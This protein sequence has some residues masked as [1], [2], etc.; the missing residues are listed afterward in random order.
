MSARRAFTL[1]ELLV[2]IAIIAILMSILLP[3]LNRVREQ[4]K[5]AACLSN[6]RQLQLAWLMYADENDDRLVNG[7]AGNDWTAFSAYDPM[8]H[9]NENP[10]TWDVWTPTLTL[11]AKRANIRKGALWPYV[12]QDK[13]YK[14]PTGRRGEIVTYSI[15][16]SMNSIYHEPEFTGSPVD[17]DWH[18]KYIKKRTEIRNMP[19]RMVFIDEGRLTP[20]G[21][22]VHY[23]VERWWDDPPARHGD[24]TNQSFADG[25]VEFHKWTAVD[26]IKRARQFANA[27]HAGDWT[28]ETDQ[29]FE[30]LYWMQKC[31]W[32]ILGYFPSIR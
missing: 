12:K 24:G 6:C 22:A 17:K 18:G 14:C 21:Y 20:D 27:D 15:M 11:D 1:I 26:T 4:G 29:G 25:H 10:W 31:T 3:A 9:T 16:F 2:V 30:E 19:G 28:P 7:A 23:N 5:R 13:L 8:K 32:G